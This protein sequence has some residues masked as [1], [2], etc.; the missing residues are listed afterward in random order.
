MDPSGAIGRWVVSLSSNGRYM[1]LSNIS[2][3]N[4]LPGQTATVDLYILTRAFQRRPL[5]DYEYTRRSTSPTVAKL[6]PTATRA[7]FDTLQRVPVAT[8]LAVPEVLQLIGETFEEIDG[9]MLGTNQRGT[10]SMFQ[11]G[12]RCP[13]A[14]LEAGT[15]SG[16]RE[17][18]TTVWCDGTPDFKLHSKFRVDIE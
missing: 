9:S 14:V 15:D 1:F 3:P 13:Q 16:L 8:L 7:G 4:L 2:R 18:L 10:G 5:L 17:I 11:E 12:F 6:R